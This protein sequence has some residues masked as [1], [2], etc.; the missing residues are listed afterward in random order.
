[1]LLKFKNG[2][3]GYAHISCN[4]RNLTRHELVFECEDGAIVLENKDSVIS[5][6]TI[7]MYDRNG[8][9]QL[10]A[11]RDKDRKDEDER[12]KIIRKLAAKFVNSCINNKQMLPSFREG[13]RVQELIEKI[14]IEKIR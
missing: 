9:K 2:I 3:T 1:M 8:V 7:K 4:C 11:A 13:L 12:V 14:R 6:F 10:R 5:N